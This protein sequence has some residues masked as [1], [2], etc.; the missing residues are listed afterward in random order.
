MRH[1]RRLSVSTQWRAAVLP[2][3]AAV[4]LGCHGEVGPT[5]GG[6]HVTPICD[7]TDPAQVVVP[8]RILLLTSTQLINM[9]QLVSTE[10]ATAVVTDAIFEVTSDFRARFPPAKFET[11]K[12]IPNS[13]E[14]TYF[15]LLAQHVGNYVRDHFAAVTKCATPATDDCAKAY[16]NALAKKVYRRALT[17]GEQERFTA[18][19]D[20]L[21]SQVVNGCQVTNSVEQAT[22]HAIY[23]LFMTPQLLWRWELGSSAAVSSG[24]AGVYLSD[25]ELASNLSFFLTDQPPDDMLVAAASAGNLRA[26]LATHV[27]RILATQAARDWLTKVMRIYFTLNQL[28]GVV[29]DS[30]KFPIVDGGAIYGDLEEESKRF[31]YDVMWNGKVMDLITSRKT[32]VNTNLATMVYGLAA[33]PAGA[34]PTN[35]VETTLPENERAGMLTNAGFITRAARTNGVGVVPR[36]LAVKALFLCLETDPPPPEIAS[37]V[38]AQKGML[39][40]MT[41]QQQ[42]ATRASVPLCA[43]CHDT[44]DSY[45]LVL[46]WYDV[47]GRHRATDHVNMPIDGTTTLPDEVGG[48]TVHSAV[49]LADVLSKNT[50][51]MN[52]MARTML[53]YGLTDATVELPVPAKQQRG[54]A[55]A[56]VANTVQRSGNKS[57]TD[58]VRAVATSPAFVLRQQVP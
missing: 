37:V 34:T 5:G 49:E 15:D 30:T 50:V 26:N 6:G 46:D 14:L 16:L 38:E 57:F 28:P 55:A 39:D 18:L 23:A 54:C 27:D 29:I 2:L 8:Q 12:S 4:V 25:N 58:M 19:Y 32:F 1:V 13:T 56:G 10:E 41:A 3:C 20:T 44:F 48:Q 33:P 7:A 42:V 31:L 40:M 21:R 52:C 24:P 17:T 43:S 36:G 22:G 51:F 35:F 11:R 47:I 45:G 53:Q 9:V